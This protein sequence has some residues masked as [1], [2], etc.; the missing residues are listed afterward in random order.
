VAC[1]AAVTATGRFDWA[2][3]T[4]TTPQILL[5]KIKLSNKKTH[6]R[7]QVSAEGKHIFWCDLFGC[8]SPISAA[9]LIIPAAKQQ[10]QNLE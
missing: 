9:P 3:E 1:H 2:P 5:K 8:K 7:R 10:S 6:P 4:E